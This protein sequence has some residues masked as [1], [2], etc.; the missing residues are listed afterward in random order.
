MKDRIN[1][2]VL[3]S[4]TSTL[5]TLVRLINLRVNMKAYK[6]WENKIENIHRN[7]IFIY[8]EEPLSD[9][10]RQMMND[11]FENGGILIQL[12]S[13]DDEVG[14]DY[15]I[16]DG[17]FTNEE[18]KSIFNGLDLSLVKGIDDKLNVKIIKSNGVFISFSSNPFSE[19][20]LN[21]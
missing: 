18:F 15:I 21:G 13:L 1:I 7:D 11:F 5:F 20:V 10:A 2:G 4:P 8:D 12:F 17:E 14:Y 3:V 19:S 6:I 16:K 9:E